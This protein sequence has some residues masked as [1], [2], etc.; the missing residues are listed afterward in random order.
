MMRNRIPAA[1]LLIAFILGPLLED[2]VRQS[3]LMSGRDPRC[4]FRGPI[5]WFFWTVTL[6]TVFAITRST[7]R[8]KVPLS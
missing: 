5:T 7:L 8:K 4:L 2:N 6:I 3:R 1:P